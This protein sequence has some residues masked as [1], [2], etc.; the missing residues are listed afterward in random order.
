MSKMPVNVLCG[1]RMAIRYR[2]KF[3]A[4]CQDFGCLFL[5]EYRFSCLRQLWRSCCKTV[6]KV[7]GRVTC[8]SKDRKETLARRI[9]DPSLFPHKCRV[10]YNVSYNSVFQWFMQCG[11]QDKFWRTE[12]ST[13]HWSIF[14]LKI[15]LNFLLL[16]VLPCLFR[17]TI[18][19]YR[20]VLI[21]AAVEYSPRSHVLSLPLTL[22]WPG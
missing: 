11:F 19:L 20:P 5:G 10:F 7:A 6:S 14:F 15:I 18:K 12:G 13:V 1:F 21:F 16:L 8:L 2:T 3:L 4:T 22:I 17:Q 9:P